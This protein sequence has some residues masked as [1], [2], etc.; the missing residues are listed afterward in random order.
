MKKLF[1]LLTLLVVAIGTSWGQSTG[2]DVIDQNGASTGGAISKTGVTL[3]GTYDAGQGGGAI[4]GYSPSNKGVKLRTQ[5]TKVTVDD[6]SYGYAILEANAG[7]KLTSFKLEGTSNGSNSI[8]L[9]GVYTDIDTDNLATSLASATNLIDADVTY[10]NKNTTYVA[11]DEIAIEAESNIVLLFPGSGDNQMRA[12]ITIDWEQTS[13]VAQEITAATLYGTAISAEDLETLKSTKALTVDGSSFSGLGV[14]GVT[15]SSGATTPTVAIS[16]NNAVYSFSINSGADEYTVT[17]TN[18]VKT[19]DAA[20]GSVVYYDADALSNSSKT[21][22]IDDIAFNY[23][24]KTFGYANKTAGVTLGGTTYKPIKLSTGEAVTVTFPTGK[25]A[26]KIIVYGWSVGG[27]GKLVNFGDGGSNTIDT[28]SD[29]FYGEDLAVNTYPSVYE[30]D[31]DNWEAFTFQGNG[32]Q[33]FVVFD[34]VF[35]SSGKEASDLAVSD[36]EASV[37]IEATTDVTYTTT[38]TGTVTVESSAPAVAT[39]TVDESTKTITITGVA[40]GTATITVSQ[41][42]DDNYDSGSKTIAVTVTDPNIKTVYDV[43]GL[44]SD[45]FVLNQTNVTN[46]D[47]AF[48]TATDNWQTG[49]DKNYGAY[50]GLFLNMSKADRTITFKVK[51]AENFRVLVQNSTSGR[52][53]TVKVGSAAVQTITHGGAGVESSDVFETGSTDEVTITIAG[54]GNGSVYPVAIQFNVPQTTINL[55]AKGFA[56]YSSAYDFTFSGAQAYKMSLDEEAKTITGTEVTGKIAAGEGILF[57]GEANAEVTITGTTGASALADNSLSGTTTASGDKADVPSICYTLSG[58]TFKKFT[59]TSFNDNKAYIEGTKTLSSLTI[60]F[61]G[62]EATSVEAIAEAAEA[63]AP[64]KVIKN[65]K[66][67]IGNYNVAGQQVK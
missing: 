62:E 53:Y 24:S 49:S 6:T 16:G 50:T 44:T 39:A 61:E 28:S 20:Q 33:P 38:S 5:Q 47:N 26:T 42:E 17:V 8:A 18:V 25:K 31:V 10:P 36:A 23:A 40:A 12:I 32:G 51:G 54:T 35:A 1:T 4:S 48:V 65:G 3:L 67:Y 27:N 41:A 57:K 15:L 7:Y 2:T 45:E 14:L 56:T 60:V 52:D 59:G 46:A 30:Y 11:S 58:D 29:I 43:T 19:Y 21:L 64:V 37:N 55:N 13:V 9:K 63:V 34:F 22:T 66:L